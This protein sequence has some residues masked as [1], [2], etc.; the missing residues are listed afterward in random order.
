MASKEMKQ[1]QVMAAFAVGLIFAIGLG[2]SGMTQ[3][4]KV[5]GFLRLGEGWDPSLMFVM[6]GAIPVH[7][8]VYRL[9]KG[10]S[11][12]LFD[13]RWH[14]PTSREINKPLVIG[15]L[16]FGLGW[17]LGG[18]CPGPALSSGGALQKEALVFLVTMTIGMLLHKQYQKLTTQKK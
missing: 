10:R 11:S 1:K 14:L 15:G 8:I 5:I 4:E 18:F 3:P 17:G 2:I 9:V 16:L 12:P 6:L 7:L 13:N